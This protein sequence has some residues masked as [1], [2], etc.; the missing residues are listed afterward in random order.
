MDQRLKRHVSAICSFSGKGSCC[1]TQKLRKLW[2]QGG[3]WKWKHAADS[4]KLHG[5]LSCP[6]GVKTQIL[7]TS[8][9]LWSKCPNKKCSIQWSPFW[10]RSAIMFDTFDLPLIDD[11][12]NYKPP[13]SN[14]G[15]SSQTC[16][17]L[18]EGKSHKIALNLHFPMVFPRFPS[19]SNG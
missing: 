4:S 5:C 14:R 1:S 10:V 2:K 6:G 7:Q 8:F 9:K 11:F 17:W 13:F 19:N 18:P 16:G 15:F 3:K 12:P